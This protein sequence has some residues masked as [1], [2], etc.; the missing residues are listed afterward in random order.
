[1]KKSLMLTAALAL[2]LS[3]GAASAADTAGFNGN[4][5]VTITGSQGF[6]GQHCIQLSNGAAL[7]DNSNYGA[8]KVIGGI[9]LVYIQT[10]GSGQELASLVFASP[11]RNSMIGKG[12]FNYIQGGYSFDSGTEVFGTKGGC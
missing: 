4:W 10:V 6:N 3:A 12:E 7:L 8:F 5:P 1:M 2:A 11:A 9:M